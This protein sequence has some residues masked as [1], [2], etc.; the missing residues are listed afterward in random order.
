MTGFHHGRYRAA[1]TKRAANWVV[2]PHPLFAEFVLLFDS[3]TLLL[4][5]AFG[6]TDHR[7]QGRYSKFIRRGVSIEICTHV[8]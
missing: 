8:R 4:P 2:C 1:V 6:I 3:S 7:L 5:I